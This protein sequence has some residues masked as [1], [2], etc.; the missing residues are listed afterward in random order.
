M[1]EILIR[2]KNKMIL[3][4]GSAPAPND[5]YIIT[6]MKNVES[7]GF[8]FSEELFK[9]LQTLE[10]AELE[11]FYLELVPILKN[12]IGAD[13]VYRPMYPNF[14]MSVMG[15]Q[16]AVLY[17]NAMVHYWSFGALYPSVKKE[18][19]LPL[20]DETKVRVLGL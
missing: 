18:K 2:R 13:V 17:L 5:S 6:I 1:N 20:F 11:N 8:T 9:V 16:E 10:K 15:E 14:P 19:R 7:L 3:K 12:L 4:S